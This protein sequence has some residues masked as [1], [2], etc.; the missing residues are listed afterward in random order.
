MSAPQTSSEDLAEYVGLLIDLK[1][2][3]A[4]L[5]TDYLEK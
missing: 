3:P 2:S 5:R 4:A 1:E